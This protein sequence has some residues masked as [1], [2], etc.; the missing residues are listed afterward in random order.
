LQSSGELPIFQ[1]GLPVVA[2]GYSCA[3]LYLD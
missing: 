1:T 2:L 3:L